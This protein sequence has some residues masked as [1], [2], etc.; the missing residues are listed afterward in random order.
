MFERKMD[1]KIGMF[2]GKFKPEKSCI[3]AQ[4]RNQLYLFGKLNLEISDSDKRLIRIIGYEFPFE[5][6]KSRGQCADLIGYD[7]E[8]TLYLIELKKEE[9]NEKIND[10]IDQINGYES[11]LN[12]II[13]EIEIE[14]R[15]EFFFESF[16][17][18]KKIVKI[19]LI[20]K[21]YYDKNKVTKK[22]YH[23]NKINIYI[24]SY[25]RIKN[26]YNENGEINLLEKKYTNNYI[27]LKVEN[28]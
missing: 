18:N 7:K 14:I 21:T 15:K 13:N 28:K 10:M 19:I 6:E 3:E 12:K 23:Y 5:S 26:V 4:I 16:I 9:T 24:C 1:F 27:S 20:G 17:L 25:A 8:H 2:H 22:E 11:N